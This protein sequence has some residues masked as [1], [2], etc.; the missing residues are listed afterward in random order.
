M[1]IN[2]MEDKIKNIGLKKILEYAPVGIHAIDNNYKTIL[3]NEAMADLEGLSIEKVIGKDILDVFPSLTKQTST[4]ITAM[5]SGKNILN[6]MQNYKNTKGEEITTVNTTVPL[7]DG[8]KVIGALEISNNMTH[9][10]EISDNIITLQKEIQSKNIDNGINRY[11]FDDL[12][13]E[14]ELLRQ[15]KEIAKMA[16]NSSS[17]I[18]IYGETG[19]G[20]E[21]FAQSIHYSGDRRNKPFIAQNC[22]AIPDTLLEGILFGTEKGSFTG[23]ESNPGIFEQANGGTLLLDEINSMSIE[24]QAKLLRV[25]QEGYIRRIGGKEDIPIDVRIIATTNQE[26]RESIEKGIIRKDLFYRLNVISLTLPLLKDRKSD[27]EILSQHFIE[28]YNQRLNKNINSISMDVLRLFYEYSWPG[29]VREL[30]NAIESAMNLATKNTIELK[31]EHFVTTI[32]IM[33]ND[34]SNKNFALKDE[35]LPNF[36]DRVE[37]ELII[38]TLAQYEENITKAADALGVSRQSLQYKLKKYDII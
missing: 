26:P 14:H 10:R 28:K 13:G 19:T 37:K 17:S 7:Y 33:N 25:L 1:K 12:I 11:T 35:T 38:D 32:S 16:S 21:L 4:L 36:L 6:R 20:K 24:L 9:I 27:I 29:N 30:E 2:S 34:T 23:A 5:E 22:A 3:Y 18:L 15:T 31:P 8:K